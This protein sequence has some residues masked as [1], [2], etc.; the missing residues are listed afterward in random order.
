MRIN[1]INP[2]MSSSRNC[3]PNS[4]KRINNCD[5]PQ[6]DVAFKGKYVN[7]PTVLGSVVLACISKTLG[8]CAF[9]TAII[10]ESMDDNQN[11]QRLRR[12]RDGRIF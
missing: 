11:N 7:F 12:S 10:L 2:T 1:S 8:I 6:G 3:K 4:Q 9:L 5:T